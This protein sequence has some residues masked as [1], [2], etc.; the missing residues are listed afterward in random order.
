MTGEV[1]HRRQLNC[2]GP[3][4]C[5][6]G[7]LTSCLD[8]GWIPVLDPAAYSDDGRLR[9]LSSSQCASA[10]CTPYAVHASLREAILFFVNG[11][12]SMIEVLWASRRSSQPQQTRSRRDPREIVAGLFKV[13]L[14]ICWTVL[15][16][17]VTLS[18][19]APSGLHGIL[20]AI[21]D[22]VQGHR[23]Q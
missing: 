5:R 21:S 3:V 2:K 7:N 9:C 11:Y 4:F 14:E 18:F 6:N 12:S 16:W 15:F 1:S 22:L 23:I 19:V 20:K 10:G 13:L 17:C 8:R